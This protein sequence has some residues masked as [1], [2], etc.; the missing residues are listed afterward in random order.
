MIIADG[1]AYRNVQLN[2]KTQHFLALQKNISIEFT[3]DMGSGH[4]VYFGSDAATSIT[5][6]YLFEAWQCG[7][8]ITEDKEPWCD[9]VRN[10]VFAWNGKYI[11]VFK[12]IKFLLLQFQYSKFSF[13]VHL[14]KN[15]I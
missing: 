7:R 2:V 3:N 4:D 13:S 5:A 14:N 12:G 9:R 10:G 1:N 8:N 11:I 15:M 6:P